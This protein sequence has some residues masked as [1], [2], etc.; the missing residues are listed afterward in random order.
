MFY[1]CENL[2][3]VTKLPAT[4]ISYYSYGAY[5]CMFENCESLNTLN[6]FNTNTVPQ[7]TNMRNTFKNCK[8]LETLI[9]ERFHTEN[10][11]Y[12]ESLFENCNSLETLNI[13]NFN[14]AKVKN[15]ANMFNN[16]ASLR[17]ICLMVALP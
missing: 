3:Y 9:L 6:L 14:F 2:E 10:V 8:V 11:E 4:E 17:S 12:M 13:N 1:G 16:C 15:M 7:I 5:S